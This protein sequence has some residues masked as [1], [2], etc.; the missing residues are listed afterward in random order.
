[1]VR[2]F[3]EHTTT[4]DF[5][6]RMSPVFCIYILSFERKVVTSQPKPNTDVLEEEERLSA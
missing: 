5:C 1:M 6:Q 3:Q 2:F 4:G